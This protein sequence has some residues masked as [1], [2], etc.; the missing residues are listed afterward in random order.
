MSSSQL[1]KVDE[2]QQQPPAGDVSRLAEHL[3]RHEAGKLVSVLTSIFGIERLQLAEDV[4]QEALLRA[5]Q[6]W[7]F[8][9]IPK[10]PAAWITQTAKNMALDVL[11][12]EKTFR[13]KE[14]AIIATIERE[15]S[16][17][18]VAFDQEISDERLRMMFVCCHPLIPQEAQVALALKTLCGFSSSEISKA[19]L[20]TEAAIEK[21][22]V[23][24]RQKIREA[25]I[26]FEIPA[27]KELGARLDAVLQTLY[28]LFNEG[29]KASSGDR[30][31]RQD[32][33]DEAIRL[34][35]LLAGHVAG[36]YPKTHALLALM[37]LNAA[38]FS[39]RV[40]EQGNILRLKEQDR[41]AWSQPMIARGMLHLSRAA[42][43]DELTAYHVQA[44]IAA[45]HCSAPDYA[46]TDWGQILALYDRLIEVDDSAVIALNRAV[47][48]AQ[49]NGPK[50]G[51]EA[52]ANI[53][54]RESLESY[55][56][57]YA[58]LGDFEAQ[59]KNFATAAE[60]LRRAIGLTELKSERSFLLKRLQEC[61]ASPSASL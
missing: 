49:V 7:P 13:G 52:V 50:A 25:R 24:A 8:Y 61:D 23:R 19:F 17:D 10:N 21:R 2:S 26:A 28:L 5:L 14:A 46:S 18:S 42:A 12:R 33:C 34:T 36:N 56:L 1:L 58:V 4:V 15:P 44:G 57:L 51:I 16:G 43:G 59:L 35:A 31:I 45:C 40:D 54:K 27:G 48:L 60:H 39:A 37:L 38:R 30:L 20:T 53:R 47:A 6:T 32:L 9:G 55:Y 3:F 29:Y 11:R 22:L 41:S